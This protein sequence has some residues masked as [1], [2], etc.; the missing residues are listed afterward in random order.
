[1]LNALRKGAGGW[2]A[3]L[4]IALLVVSFAV[5]GV[6]GFLTGFQGDTV[7]TVGKTD[8]SAQQFFREY[9]LAKRRLG[10]QIGQAVTDA[11]TTSTAP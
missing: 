5:R 11:P 9:D 2:I 8:V 3:Q 1:M 4:F 6:S 10:Q 7:A